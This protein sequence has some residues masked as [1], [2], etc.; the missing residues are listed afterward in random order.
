MPIVS[1]IFREA[2]SLIFGLLLGNWHNLSEEP[3]GMKY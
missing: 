3:F 2:V 1:K